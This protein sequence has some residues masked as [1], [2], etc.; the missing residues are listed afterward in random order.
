MRRYQDFPGVKANQ[1]PPREP[2]A[3][4]PIPAPLRTGPHAL[5]PFLPPGIIGP[6]MFRGQF[7]FAG[8]A[9]TLPL[10]ILQ[11]GR[12]I[13]GKTGT[14]V[15]EQVPEKDGAV[16]VFADSIE[17]SVTF[18]QRTAKKGTVPARGLARTV[19]LFAILVLKCGNTKTAPFFS[20]TGYRRDE[21]ACGRL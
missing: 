11:T 20:N 21:T 3:S 13:A 8:A 4:F 19:P 16:P 9:L 10:N 12:L 1:P 14:D 18:T 15:G 7:L 17:N 6:A 5:T 2:T